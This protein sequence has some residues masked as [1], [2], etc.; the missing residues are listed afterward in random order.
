MQ[1]RHFLGAG[2]SLTLAG[3]PL[4]AGAQTHH[5]AY[6]QRR[7]L[8]LMLRGGMDGLC[9][10]PPTGDPRLQALRGN[11]VP[12]ELLRGNDFF[13]V[14][15]ALPT[16]AA[17]MTQGQAVAV[18]A[19][20]FGYTG[21]SHFEGQDIMQ[22]GVTK[23]YA[24]ASGWLGRAMEKAQLGAGVAISIPMPLILRG[25]SK[26]ETQFPTWMPAPPADTY[27]LIEQLWQG[28]P[29]LAAL[30]SRLR[31]GRTQA[32]MAGAPTPAFDN[33]KSAAGLA[34]EAALR[35]Q[36]SDG[37]MVGLIDFN[38]FDTH[39]AQ[40]AGEGVHA[41]RLKQVDDAIRSFRQSMGPR[42]DDCLVL[43]VTEFGRTAAEN[44]TTGTDHGWGGCILAAGGLV[45]T[46]GVVADWPG[47]ETAR[48]FEGRDLTVTVDAAAVYA[49]ALHSVF[50]LSA[51][52]VQDGVLSHRPHA[53]TQTLFRA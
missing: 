1:R 46:A 24:S 28:H 22:S 50:G 5:T 13:G 44:G 38:G 52:Q 39:A 29:E 51:A 8:V 37:P 10:I 17:L 14:H 19:T 20:G 36:A 2:A 31:S 6:G 49:Q 35:M 26:S 25:D 16:L 15:P 53:L 40:G 43:T 30:G 9:A 45:R 32:D 42:W 11:L 3:S 47:L 48:L 41:T 21:R 27:A 34:H 4:L 33:R 23:P 18:H 7:L 12:G